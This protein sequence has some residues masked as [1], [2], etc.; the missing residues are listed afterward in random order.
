M[1]AFS[2]DRYLRHFSRLALCGSAASS[3]I[4]PPGPSP[5]T[6]SPCGLRGGVTSPMAS[7]VGVFSSPTSE[8]SKCAPSKPQCAVAVM[9]SSTNGMQVSR[10]F[11]P[12]S[13][14]SVV[15]A[16]LPISKRS[17]RAERPFSPGNDP[18]DLPLSDEINPIYGNNPNTKDLT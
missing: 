8:V 14:P 5:R 1:G 12:M 3:L 2:S 7:A 16:P 17:V 6:P 9:P 13:L 4:P 18:T 10:V 15:L 11:R